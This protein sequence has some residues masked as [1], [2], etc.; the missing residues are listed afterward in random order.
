MTVLQA[1]L[2][3]WAACAP[4]IWIARDGLGPDS[5]ESG[6]AWAAFK[7]VVQWGVP[8]LLLI[9]PFLALRLVDRRMA[10]HI[11]DENHVGG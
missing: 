3:V 10:R 6:G 8:A 2:I 11:G 5:H 9:V 4:L 1:G 7:F